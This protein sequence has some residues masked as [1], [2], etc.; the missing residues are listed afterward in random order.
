VIYVIASDGAAFEVWAAREHHRPND[1]RLIT[2][3]GQLAGIRDAEI[4]IVH[5]ILDSH[6]IQA[7]YEA[8]YYR[9]DIR[10]RYATH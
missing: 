10:I 1:V 6:I 5:G 7:A 4:V 9:H 2:D 3:P 8:A